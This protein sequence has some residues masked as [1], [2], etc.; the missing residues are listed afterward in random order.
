MA[1]PLNDKNKTTGFA[2]YKVGDK[3]IPEKQPTGST[4]VKTDDSNFNDNQIGSSLS[5]PS[6][7]LNNNEIKTNITVA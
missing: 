7:L 2:S 6:P 4:Q 1:Q 3:L 5:S